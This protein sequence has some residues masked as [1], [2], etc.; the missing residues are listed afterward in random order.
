MSEQDI[1]TLAKEVL[2]GDN[3]SLAKAISVIENREQG[4]RPLISHLHEHAG[5]GTIVGITGS[6]GAGKSTLVDRLITAYR[7]QGKSVGVLSI[8]PSSPYTGGAILG[9]RIRMTGHTTDTGV[10]VRS[11][12][13][14]GSLG[15]LS[16]STTDAAIALDAFGFDVVL[17]ETV[18]AGQNEIDIVRT[19]DLVVVLVPPSSGDDVQ[20]LKAGIL[21]IADV[22]VVNKADLAGAKQTFNDLTEMVQ[23]TSHTET[24][25]SSRQGTDQTVTDGQDVPPIVKT[26]AT[27]GEGIQELLAVLSDRYEYLSETG[28]LDER[29]RQRYAE[30][31]RRLVREDLDQ[32]V[33]ENID[34]HGGISELVEYIVDGEVDP[35]K[36][37]SELAGTVEA[38]EYGVHPVNDDST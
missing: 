25:T 5:N 26:V 24:R 16:N 23:R 38:P 18:G 35:Y 19:A 14:R 11:M 12:S 3:V 22:F 32:S 37:A 29:V 8:D 17:I 28:Q 4:Y 36:L 6:P 2:E 31:L 13:T 27:T 9:D 10:F 33:K 21:E 30:T 7:D 1:A 34:S 20:M 15:G